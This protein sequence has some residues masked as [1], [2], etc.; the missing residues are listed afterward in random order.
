[1]SGPGGPTRRSSPTWPECCLTGPRRRRKSGR[2]HGPH[3]R[4]PIGP[5]PAAQPPRGLSS[6]YRVP[7][8]AGIPR[9]SKPSEARSLPQAPH[10]AQQVRRTA[11]HPGAAT[12]VRRRGRFRQPPAL[13]SSPRTAQPLSTVSRAGV[14]GR[15]GGKPAPAPAAPEAAVAEEDQGH[16]AA[17]ADGGQTEGTLR[18]PLAHPLQLGCGAGEPGLRA[19]GRLS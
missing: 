3:R 7:R 9:W 2:G 18:L 4:G 15:R 1:M 14:K 12:P 8:N 16:E 11:P 17:Q 10:A 13:S 6:A 5:G 19:S